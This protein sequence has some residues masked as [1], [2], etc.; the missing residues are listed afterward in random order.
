MPYKYQIP[1]Y[2]RVCY[3]FMERGNSVFFEAKKPNSTL[4]FLLLLL[5]WQP[6]NRRL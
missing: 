4:N 5:Y 3:G 2:A 1:S 6:I